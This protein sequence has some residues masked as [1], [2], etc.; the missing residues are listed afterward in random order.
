MTKLRSLLLKNNKTI[1]WYPNYLKE[2]RFGEWLRDVKDWAVSRDRYWGTPLPVWQCSNGHNN[3]LG[4]V[5]DLLA[6]S[7]SSNHYLFFAM[8][9]RNA[10]FR[11]LLVVG[12]NL[13]PCP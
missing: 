1:H 6:Q 3:F 4:S 7:Y 9:N 8:A 12:P 10:K 2:G 5:A 13:P 11:K